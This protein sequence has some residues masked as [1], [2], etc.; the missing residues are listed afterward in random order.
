MLIDTV[1]KRAIQIEQN[2]RRGSDAIDLTGIHIGLLLATS[3]GRDA[4][5]SKLYRE[6]RTLKLYKE[7]KENGMNTISEDALD[8]LFREARSY[9]AWL[10][11]PVAEESLR[12]LYDILKW[13]PTSANSSP[14]RF[15]F[16]RS[17]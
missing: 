7:W 12:R 4:W 17:T 3:L 6:P 1:D 5:W 8:V 15:I 11:K 13:G 2:R 16:L 14:T 9:N 10:S